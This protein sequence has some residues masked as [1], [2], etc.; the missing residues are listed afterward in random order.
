MKMMMM[1]V[2]VVVMMAVMGNGRQV[3]EDAMEREVLKAIARNRSLPFVDRMEAAD[4]LDYTPHTRYPYEKG[5]TRRTRADG[6]P[7][8]VKLS[9]GNLQN[10]E[11]IVTWRAFGSN[12]SSAAVLFGLSES[13]LN[14]RAAAVSYTYTRADLCGAPD[15]MD[16]Y[17]YEATIFS[18]APATRYYYRVGFDSQDVFSPIY[19]FVTKP[20]VGSEAASTVKFLLYGDIGG[21]WAGAGDKNA[22]AMQKYGDVARNS[23]TLMI[24]DITYAD[25]EA[26]SLWDDFAVQM[27]PISAYHPFQ[28]NMG[29]HEGVDSNG[30]C[31]I[32]ALVRYHAPNNN[33]DANS[34]LYYSFTWGPVKFVVMSTE[35]DFGRGSAQYDYIFRELNTIDR[36]VTPWLVFLG[37]KC[38]YSEQDDEFD[39]LFREVLEPVLIDAKVDLGVYGHKHDWQRFCSLVDSTCV[40]R[41]DNGVYRNPP[42]P[43]HLVVGMGGRNFDFEK[44]KKS[45]ARQQNLFEVFIEELGYG[46][47]SVNMTHFNIDFV[48]ESDGSVPDKLLI[49]KN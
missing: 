10:S 40:M 13:N 29:N 48:V 41:S 47:V 38:M 22:L 16:G 28:V 42:A 39:S 35:H 12:T 24:G 23:F 6:E 32:P 25:A 33:F 37:H 1:V 5:Q 2:A 7:F 19:N 11:M 36:S 30:E 49:I 44:K 18:L 9:I 45:L 46:R 34:D 17:V 15:G 20:A 4:R 21:P 43:V 8:G 14:G 31:F 27:E 26:D 3:V